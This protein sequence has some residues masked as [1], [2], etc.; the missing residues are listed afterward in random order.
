MPTSRVHNEFEGQIIQKCGV[1]LEEIDFGILDDTPSV[2]TL[3]LYNYSN[4]E[5]CEFEF[6]NPG[7][8]LKDEISIDPPKGLLEPG[9]HLLI[10]LKLT[11]NSLSA[12]SGELEIKINWSTPEGR[13]RE[14]K[15]TKESK[16]KVS[17]E[18]EREKLFVRVIKRSLI[19]EVNISIMKRLL[20]ASRGPL[21]LIRASL[22][23]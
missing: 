8:N 18:I 1:S 5:N 17:K 21:T 4:T 14:F 3:I 9:K 10:K 2:K 23:R 12:Y 7:F 22:S 16:D 19:K 6:F 13:E 15:E 20:K 11:S